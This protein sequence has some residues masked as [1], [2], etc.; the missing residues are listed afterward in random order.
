M[1]EI[2]FDIEADG[3]LDTVSKIHC[4]SY[5]YVEKPD[6]VT[7]VTD[8]VD[9]HRFFH[10]AVIND[11]IIIGHNIIGYDLKVVKKLLHINDKIRMIDTLP[12]SW[13]LNHDRLKHGL[14]EYGEESGFEKTK[15]E[16]DEW[17]EGR[18][19]LMAERCER[20]T[21]IN[22]HLWLKLKGKLQE[23]YDD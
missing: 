1:N 16:S 15:V 10:D 2:V 22:L 6:E 11:R 7:T 23:L 20:D 13:Y 12:L 19:E 3:L 8:Y 18:L 21:L 9:I 14:E 5:R 4:L 17:A